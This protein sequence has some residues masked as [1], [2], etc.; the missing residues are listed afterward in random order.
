MI[1]GTTLFPSFVQISTPTCLGLKGFVVVVVV[2]ISINF[3]GASIIGFGN[4]VSEQTSG[5]NRCKV[6]FLL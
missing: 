5:S 3:H 2:Q 6:C 1:S 4:K